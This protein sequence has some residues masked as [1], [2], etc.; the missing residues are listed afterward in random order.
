MGPV[1]AAAKR[2]DE[3]LRGSGG[4]EEILGRFRSGAELPEF[5]SPGFSRFV[6]L[7]PHFMTARDVTML[8]AASEAVLSAH[9]K[10]LG[11]VLG[12]EGLKSAHFSDFLA[13]T[14]QVLGLD[15][16]GPVH[17][18]CLRLDGSFKGGRP[19]FLELNADMPQGIGINDSFSGFL[20]SLP[21]YE[22]F[23]REHP[24]EVPPIRESFLRALL[25]E[26]K[27]W[28]GGGAPSICFVTWREDP[29]R[30]KDMQLNAEHFA[31]QGVEAFVADP[32]GLEFNGT[33]LAA[34]GKKIDLVYRVV[35]TAE[36]LSR[37]GEM[38]ALIRADKSGAVLSVN[39][40]RS[41][42]MGNKTMFA[43]LQDDDFQ[44]LLSHEEKKA[45]R[46]YVPWTRI[47][48]DGRDTGPSGEPVD[49]GAWVLDHREELVLKPSHDF[50]G[51]GVT[52]GSL[53][54]GEE[55]DAALSNALE[56]DFIVQT[57]G[58]TGK[59]PVPRRGRGHALK[60]DVRG[61]RPLHPPRPFLRLPH[62]PELRT[63]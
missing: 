47:M 40:F 46:E 52:L 21:F 49:L 15:Q 59:E 16:P 3:L 57:Q 51:H 35:S 13:W 30:W 6:V 48:R 55:W 5:F 32:R 38:E 25:A 1:E 7:R 26:W 37:A 36:T 29:V 22:G 14:E 18:T 45:V 62:P 60:R 63:R 9:A 53:V 44:G 28:G 56:N 4:M 43:L 34:G 42:L 58:R 41:E 31:S 50:G 23:K 24:V 12:D 20:T 27:A 10:V 39:S 2:W 61:H 54:T 8:K 17:A 33:A 19:V 11:A